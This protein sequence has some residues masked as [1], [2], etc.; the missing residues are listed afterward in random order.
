MDGDRAKQVLFLLLLAGA[1]LP[2]TSAPM[3]LAAGIAFALLLG[4]PWGSA[5]SQWSKR[6]LQLSVTG[7]GFGMSLGAV[8]RTGREALLY[9][10]IGIGA[11][12]AIGVF[13]GRLAGTGSRT[14]LLISFGT[15]ICGG[16]AIAAMA[17]VI[18][19]KDDETAVALATVFTLNSVALLL[20]PLVGHLLGLPQR[21]FGLW[22]ALAIHDTSSVVGAASAYGSLALMTATTVKLTRAVWIVPCALGAGWLLRSGGGI[23]FPVFIAGFLAA[24]A[25]RTLLPSGEPLWHEL[26]AI[27]KQSLVITLFLI[28]AGLTRDVLQK[29][30]PRPLVQ[31]LLLWMVVSVGTL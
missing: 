11:T 23:K 26:A 9:T 6:L 10:V 27:A 19:S 25:V 4:N 2:W 24:A 29:N 28:G 20:F 14:S 16:S 15:A 8:W 5:V 31:A 18:R 21:G 17:P 12:M 1:A 22:S 30:G 13:L 7:L 3:G